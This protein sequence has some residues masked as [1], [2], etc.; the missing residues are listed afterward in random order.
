MEPKER[1]ELS[2][3]WTLGWREVEAILYLTVK[4]D[5]QSLVLVNISAQ[6]SGAASITMAPFRG[7]YHLGP[8]L[9]GFQSW[10]TLRILIFFNSGVLAS[11]PVNLRW[12]SRINHLESS[13]GD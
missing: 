8:E 1:R 12:G 2:D 9:S 3:T 11:L 6:H 5:L 13:P 10:L 4:V 7:V